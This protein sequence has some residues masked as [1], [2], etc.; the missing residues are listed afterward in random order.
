M[1]IAFARAGASVV[2][3]SRKLESCQTLAKEVSDQFQIEAI[4][5][6][7]NVSNWSDCESLASAVHDRFGQVD[8][9]VNNAGMSPLYPTLEEVSEELYD[10]VLGVNLKGPFRLTS[11]VG[12]RMAAGTGGS[13]INISSVES[14]NPEPR[15]L[16]YAAAKAG[17]ETLTIGFAR[18]FGPNVRVN[19]IQC[20]MFRTDIAKSW[21]DDSVVTE[22]ARKRTALNR[23]GETDDV[24]GA[25]MY[26]ATD[27]SAYCTGATIRLD[28][29]IRT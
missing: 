15:A 28:G 17:L 22:Y 1:V 3:A 11:L 4:P 13:I 25:A 18:A 12:T 20:G 21:G 23:I 19:T 24:V 6:S 27:A 9:L 26:L 16:P 5:I 2:I 7:T 10:K 8:V 14:S 29:G